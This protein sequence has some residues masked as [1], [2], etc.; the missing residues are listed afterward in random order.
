MPLSAVG[1]GSQVRRV[2]TARESET[3]FVT[4]QNKVKV[5]RSMELLDAGV[6]GSP[7]ELAEN[8]MLSDKLV[9]V[10]NLMHIYCLDP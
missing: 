4:L 8:T 7:L 9:M 1:L 10:T 5:Y 2:L 3:V 6:Q